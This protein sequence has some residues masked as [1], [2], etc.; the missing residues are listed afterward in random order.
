MRKK[1]GLADY[2]YFPEPDLP[3]LATPPEFVDRVRRS[4]AELPS[5]LRARLSDAGLPT[6]VALI[7]AEEVE[8]AKYFDAAVAAGADPVQ[9]GNWI[10]RDLMQ[11]CKE[12]AVRTLDCVVVRIWH[13]LYTCCSVQQ[14]SLS[15]HCNGLPHSAVVAMYGYA[16]HVQHLVAETAFERLKMPRHVAAHQY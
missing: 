5:A 12:H 15:R 1:E 16:L 2:R 6:D 8:T 11:W 9:A 7:V 4:M 13:R 10:V 14:C 3:P